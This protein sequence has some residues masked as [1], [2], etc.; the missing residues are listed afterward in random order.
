MPIP[1]RGVTIGAPIIWDSLFTSSEAPAPTAPPPAKMTGF[2][3]SLINLTASGMPE[4]SS[5]GFLIPKCSFVIASSIWALIWSTGRSTCTGPGRPD[6]AICQ[7]S[8]IAWGSLLTSV[9]RKLCLV[10][11]IIRLYASTSWKASEPRTLEPT[12]PVSA[13]IGMESAYAVAIPVTMLVAPGPEVERQTP[14][15]PV[16]RA[17]PSAAWAAHCSCLTSTC[18]MEESLI[19]SYMGIT[20]PPG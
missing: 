9:T 13:S 3:H 18:L 6:A 19:S 15:L 16:A 8:S 12:C 1:M 14:V 5:Q 20:A 11:D 7:A 17:Y 4:T 2:W 10:T